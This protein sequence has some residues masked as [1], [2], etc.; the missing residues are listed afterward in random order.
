MNGNY[1]NLESRIDR[2][3]HFES[4]IKSNPF[5]SNIQHMNAITHDN[6][7]IGCSKSHLTIL[8]MFE[9][10]NDPYIVVMEDDFCILNQDNFNNFVKDFELIKDSTEWKIIV[11]TPSGNSVHGTPEMMHA[12]FKRI[13]NTQTTTGYII[14]K[15][16]IPILISNIKESVNLQLQGLPSCISAIDIFWKQLQQKYPFYYYSK[17]FGG[18]LPGWSCIEKRNVNYNERFIQQMYL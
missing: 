12:N 16:M 6:P 15:E 8:E 9:T 17:I 18:Q 14:K 4:N 5:F 1:I 2:K 10:T 13:V 3:T 11:L 7:A